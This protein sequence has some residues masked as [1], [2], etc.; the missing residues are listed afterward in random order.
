MLDTVTLYRDHRKTNINRVDWW[1]TNEAET[2]AIRDSIL[3]SYLIYRD[4]GTDLRNTGT[5]HSAL[6]YKYGFVRAVQVQQEN[7]AWSGVLAGVFCCL[8][9][10][11]LSI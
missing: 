4:S 2:I 1:I 9:F 7:T 3:L 10:N 6:H 11:A 5:L 8:F